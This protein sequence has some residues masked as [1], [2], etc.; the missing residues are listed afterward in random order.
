VSAV[1]QEDRHTCWSCPVR[2]PTL[3]SA[4]ILVGIRTAIRNRNKPSAME[5]AKVS[6]AVQENRY[7]CA[8]Y[9]ESIVSQGKRTDKSLSFFVKRSLGVILEERIQDAKD[10]GRSYVSLNTLFSVERT[11]LRHRHTE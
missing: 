8:G 3:I 1:V 6:A 11:E 7:T 5:C 9:D 2:K 4:V 10:Q